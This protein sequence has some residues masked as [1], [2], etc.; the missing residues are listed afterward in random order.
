MGCLRGVITTISET[1]PESHF[2]SYAESV[3]TADK[4]HTRIV[5]DED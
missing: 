2:K 1:Y 5:R 3:L 4:E